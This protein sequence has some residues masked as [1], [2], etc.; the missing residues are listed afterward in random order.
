LSQPAS[1]QKFRRGIFIK[2]E[3]GVET[4]RDASGA[5]LG[6][7]GVHAGVVADPRLDPFK[8]PFN[9]LAV[10]DGNAGWGGSQ[11]ALSTYGDENIGSLPEVAVS[12]RVLLKS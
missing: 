6:V 11:K 4:D 8:P 12:G 7:G 3:A 5:G 2:G 9:V 1:A 10:V